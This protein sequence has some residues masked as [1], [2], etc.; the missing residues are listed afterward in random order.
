MRLY[1]HFFKARLRVYF[2]ESTYTLPLPTGS[3]F[4]KTPQH[5]IINI[6][7]LNSKNPFF[8]QVCKD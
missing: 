7:T 1:L 8:Q 3:K 4:L 6:K 5:W 2:K